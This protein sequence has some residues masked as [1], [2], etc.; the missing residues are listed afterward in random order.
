VFAFVWGWSQP[1]LLYVLQWLTI[2]LPPVVAL[3]TY[4]IVRARA[5]RWASTVR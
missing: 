2:V 5:R 1:T 4:A 3:V